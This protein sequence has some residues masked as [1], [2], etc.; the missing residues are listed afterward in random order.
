MGLRS[1]SNSEDVIGHAAG[2][3]PISEIGNPSYVGRRKHVRSRQQW[4][5]GIEGEFVEH[6]QSNTY[7]PPGGQRLQQRFLAQQT[8][9]TRVDDASL[10]G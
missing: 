4:R 3:A 6:V 9:A 7:Q 1:V 2:D 5:T 8:P 10:I